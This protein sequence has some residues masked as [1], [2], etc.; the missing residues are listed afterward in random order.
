LAEDDYAWIGGEIRKL[1]D[2]HC[3]GRVLSCLEGGYNL[4]AL[5]RSVA[6]YIRV[7]LDED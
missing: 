2:E 4:Q 5:G 1:A 6:A 7:F 3:S